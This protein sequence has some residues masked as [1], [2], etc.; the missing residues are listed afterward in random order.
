M[1][2]LNDMYT[3]L[4]LAR[5]IHGACARAV[6]AGITSKG[7]QTWLDTIERTSEALDNS[8]KENNLI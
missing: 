6:S 3:A 4:A 2:K 8:L 7:F 1:T 5:G